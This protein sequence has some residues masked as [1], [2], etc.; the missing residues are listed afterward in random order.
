MLSWSE[1]TMTFPVVKSGLIAPE[2]LVRI[3]RFTPSMPRIRIPVQTSSGPYP[4]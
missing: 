1:M 3:R 2:A 4:S